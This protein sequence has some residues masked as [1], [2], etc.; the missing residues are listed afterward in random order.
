MGKIYRSV[1]CVLLRL[2]P[3][4]ASPRV[5]VLVQPPERLHFAQNKLAA[6]QQPGQV[7]DVGL[8]VRL[9]GRLELAA[10]RRHAVRVA[11]ARK[12]QPLVQVAHGR[13]HRRS[14]PEVPA[15][16]P[17][18]ARR[19]PRPHPCAVRG[20][21]PRA[22]RP[23]LPVNGNGAA[24][25]AR[26]SRSRRSRFPATKKTDWRLAY[27]TPRRHP[28]RQR[29]VVG[30]R[31]TG[32]GPAAPGALSR[33]GM[34]AHAEREWAV[35]RVRRVAPIFQNPPQGGAMAAALHSS[36]ARHSREKRLCARP[37]RAGQHWSA[38]PPA[39]PRRRRRVAVAAQPPPAARA[40]IRA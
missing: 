32:N 19:Q 23:A 4:Q 31:E 9:E 5:P 22:R 14:Y 39:P 28:H 16:P 13:L 6:R 26:C 24:R 10:R 18:R 40:P 1:R 15:S 20:G 17:V 11:P 2:R 3:I 29:F 25:E 37:H 7:A 12:Q 34:T 21:A 38:A 33:G 36:C 30:A 27:D 35:W 8:P